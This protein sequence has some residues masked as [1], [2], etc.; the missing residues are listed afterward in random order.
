MGLTAKGFK[1]QPFASEP[2]TFTR[3]KKESD[4]NGIFYE[5]D[6]A[7]SYSSAAGSYG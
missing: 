1:S 7:D 6:T 5:Y 2:C 4:K 3:A